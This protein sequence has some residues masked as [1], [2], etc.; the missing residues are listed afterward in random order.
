[1]QGLDLFTLPWFL[2]LGAV[3]LAAFVRGTAGFGFALVLAPVLLLIL[4]PKAVVPV[5]LLLGLLSNIVVV[6]Y[7]VRQVDLKRL[8]PMAA[9]AIVGIPLGIYT[10]RVISP[11]SLK[12]LIGGTTML[13]AVPL[14]LGF[15]RAFSRERPVAG[16]AGVLSGFLGSSTSLAG[17]PVVLFMHNQSWRKEMIH[18][19]L[20][21]FFLFGSS[22][23]LIGLAL[24][25]FVSS[26]IL[27]TAASLAPGLLA[28]VGLG[29]VAFRRINERIFRVLSIAIVFV[30]GT[31]AILSG[32]GVLS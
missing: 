20:A 15:T 27:L 3:F 11:D 22:F 8:L 26:G 23:S 4:E 14:A 28:G 12:V 32:L 7:S 24:S 13:F 2:A 1:M 6:A 10:I 5:D 31:V 30:S 21:A 25:G 18:P 9:G 19:S 16:V 17:P 29:I